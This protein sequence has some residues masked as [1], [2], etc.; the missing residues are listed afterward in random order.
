MVIGAADLTI[1]ASPYRQIGAEMRAPRA[2]HNRPA[3]SISI[4]D[5]AGFGKIDADDGPI[6]EVTCEAEG[7]PGPVKF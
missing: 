3:R 5:D 6:I 7:E 1:D 2:L 4:S